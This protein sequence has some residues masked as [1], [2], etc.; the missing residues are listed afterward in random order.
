MYFVYDHALCILCLG[1]IVTQFSVYFVTLSWA[2][3]RYRGQDR[4]D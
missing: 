3:L 1:M 2:R 4:I